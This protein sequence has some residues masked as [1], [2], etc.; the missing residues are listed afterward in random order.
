MRRA[1]RKDTHKLLTKVEKS[2]FNMNYP[3]YEKYITS[4]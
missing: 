1:S 3:H 4:N 2:K